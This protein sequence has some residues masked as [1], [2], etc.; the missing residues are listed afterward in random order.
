MAR[1][2]VTRPWGW[3]GKARRAERS[4]AGGVSLRNTTQYTRKAPK[5]RK[6]RTAHPSRP[7]S[8]QVGTNKP[9]SQQKG[10][11]KKKL[12]HNRPSSFVN[13]K[14]I[15]H[16]ASNRGKKNQKKSLQS[17]KSAFKSEF[18]SQKQSFPPKTPVIRGHFH[19][20]K[21]QKMSKVVKIMSIDVKKCQ[22]MSVTVS[23][24]TPPKP[25][26]G[27]T[28]KSGEIPRQ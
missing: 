10:Q 27:E 17:A 7:A 13:R 2:S 11:K 4:V 24:K 18:S 20:S 15:Y 19:V 12:H 22:N 3:T 1:P 8:Q 9:N 23:F 6:K 28:I 25:A 26:A 5:G 14:Q 16:F 21:C